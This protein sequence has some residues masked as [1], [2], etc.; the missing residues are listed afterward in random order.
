MRS[1]TSK[2]YNHYVRSWKGV[3]HERVVDPNTASV[4]QS[5]EFLTKIY[6][7]DVGYS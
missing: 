6:E 7:V 3:C 5:T 4:V 1:K 2:K